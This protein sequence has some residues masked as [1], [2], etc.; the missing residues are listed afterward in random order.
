VRVLTVIPARIGSFRLPQKPLRSICGEPLI[1][2][3]ARRAIEL[4]VADKVIVAADDQ[5]V[6]EAV[7]GLGVRGLLTRPDHRSGTER[8]GEIVR[9]PE[10][11]DSQLVLNLQVDQPFLPAA[12][13][14]GALQL[15]R[16]GY[17]VGTA[18]AP[19][20]RG[21]LDNRCVV[22]VTLETSGRAR[23]FS[24][25]PLVTRDPPVTHDAGSSPRRMFHH[26]GVY[27]YH[28][29]TILEWISLP[30]CTSERI[31]GLEQLRPLQA[32]MSIGVALCKCAPPPAVDTEHDLRRARMVHVTMD[33]P[34]RKSA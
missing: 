18:A 32:G 20:Q 7:R 11:A 24:R 33:P 2:I 16:S 13:A 23:D 21:A 5:R 30:E 17:S 9:K 4:A 26:L 3:V 27:A 29:D 10:F 8:I 1:R 6:L 34:T 22:K 31:H 14:R 15:V 19:L 28:R 25:D 12:A